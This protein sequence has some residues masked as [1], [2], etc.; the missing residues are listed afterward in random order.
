MP[1]PRRPSHLAGPV[2][3]SPYFCSGS[4]TGRS[5]SR[6]RGAPAATIQKSAG[7]GDSGSSSSKGA[8]SACRRDAVIARTGSDT[9]TRPKQRTWREFAPATPTL[10]HE[11][12]LRAVPRARVLGVGS[13]VNR[14][15]VGRAHAYGT[16]RMEPFRGGSRA[17]KLVWAACCACLF[18]ER[19]CGGGVA[20]EG[21]VSGAGGWCAVRCL[22]PLPG[23]L[24]RSRGR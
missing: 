20:L 3:A 22:V 1:L 12:P 11:N 14:L 13:P 9:G 16:V 5:G 19:G 24:Y 6:R 10:R 7:L 23:F 8:D 2:L 15:L 21:A 18:G 17:A 4:P